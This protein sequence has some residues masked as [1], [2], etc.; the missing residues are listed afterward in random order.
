V[1]KYK[2][3]FFPAVNTLFNALV[4][5]DDFKALDHSNMKMAMGGGMAVLPSTAEAWHKITGVPIVEGYGLSET[6][7][8]ATANP[9]DIKACTGTIGI[10][11]PSTDIAIMDDDGNLVPQGE[12]GEIAIR[13][14]QVMKGYWQRP[15]ETAKVMTADGFFRSGDIGV[16]DAQGYVKIVDRKKDMILV[17]GFN[18][19]PAEIEEVITKHPKVL[20]AA[21][22]GVADEKSGEVPKLF[23]VKSDE[24]LTEEEVKAFCRDNLTGY[25]Q[26]R[27]IEFLKEL[28]KSPVGKILRKELRK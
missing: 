5:N 22:I 11:I 14:P 15:E 19:Y 7:P 27:Y 21:A 6:S 17:S 2:P 26:P 25:K 20:E 28:P 8:V 16:M 23:I 18:V 12:R 9:P 13:G 4:H 24:S 3:A 10:P 1:G